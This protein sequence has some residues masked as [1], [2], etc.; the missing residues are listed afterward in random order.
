V[1]RLIAA[2]RDNDERKVEKAVLQLARTR[3]IFVLGWFA[4]LLGIALAVMMVCHAAVPARIVSM[5][6]A[7]PAGTARSGRVAKLAAA[8]VMACSEPSSA[9]C[10]PSPG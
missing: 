9:R 5:R 7:E 1:R 6:T 8:A 10:M 4:L 3:S 2:I